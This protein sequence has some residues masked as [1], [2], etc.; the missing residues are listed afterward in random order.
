MSSFAMRNF[1]FLSDPDY[2][3]FLENLSKKVEPFPSAEVY[4]EQMEQSKSAGND[5][6]SYLSV[7]QSYIH[8]T[9]DC[10]P[11]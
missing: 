10:L 2:E 11:T 6:F 3:A 5:L 7:I 9:M 4:V 8:D 1:F